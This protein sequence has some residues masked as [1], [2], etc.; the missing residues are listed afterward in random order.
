MA[1][2]IWILPISDCQKGNGVELACFIRVQACIRALVAPSA[3][4]VLSTARAGELCSVALRGCCW[5]WEKCWNLLFF[6]Q[7]FS[8]MNHYLFG[9]SSNCPVF[10]CEQKYLA[11]L[12]D[13]D[14][15]V[16]GC[17]G[18][19]AQWCP[20]WQPPLRADVETGERFPRFRV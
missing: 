9:I 1:C 8:Q 19:P 10:A 3:L 16:T 18:A 2:E 5:L 6:F 13:V 14:L 7:A 11:L 12:R 20:R 17:S 15:P 4:G